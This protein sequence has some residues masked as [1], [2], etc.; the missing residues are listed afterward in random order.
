MKNIRLII[1]YVGTNFKGSQ[2]QPNA[3]TVQGELEK[4]LS[5][6]CVQPIETFFAGRTD[7]GVHAYGQ[8]VN[9]MADFSIPIEHLMR[10]ANNLLP[11]DLKIITL[12]EVSLDFHSRFSPSAKT[13]IYKIYNSDMSNI[14]GS[15]NYYHIPQPLDFSAMQSSASQFIGTHDFSSF[16]TTGSS[17]TTFE[18]TIHSC[19]ISKHDLP[20]DNYHLIHQKGAIITFEICG[21][22]FL[23]NMVRII[24]G[25]LIEVGL[26]KIASSQITDIINGHDRKLAG[27]VAPASGLYL[28]EITYIGDSE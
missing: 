8:V 11:K 18:R 26:G 25:T 20:D 13:Y 22:G 28:K 5:K 16:M 6:L 21:N 9:F 7:S 15:D 24:T 2:I 17:A 3:R 1:Q 27:H 12:E 10:A 19:L 23:Y 4:V 14:F